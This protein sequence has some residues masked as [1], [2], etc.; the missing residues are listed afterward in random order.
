VDEVKAGL[1][2]LP[3]MSQIHAD[4]KQALSAAICVICG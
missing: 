2:F 4:E 3:Q 1:I